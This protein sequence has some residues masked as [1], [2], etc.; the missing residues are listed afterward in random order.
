[1]SYMPKVTTFCS[2]TIPTS[3][4][5]FVHLIS[6]RSKSW[7]KLYHSVLNDYK[8]TDQSFTIP[9]FISDVITSSQTVEILEGLKHQ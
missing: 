8:S 4:N 2:L 7:W 1:M 6:F 3:N 5:N 9:C